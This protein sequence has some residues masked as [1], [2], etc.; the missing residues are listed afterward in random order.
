MTTFRSAPDLSV[1][2]LPQ[3]IVTTTDADPGIP[4]ANRDATFPCAARTRALLRSDTYLYG[5]AGQTRHG[6]C[7]PATIFSHLCDVLD[8]ICI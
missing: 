4:H 2:P 8:Q 6:T 3:S 1:I 5:L 7:N